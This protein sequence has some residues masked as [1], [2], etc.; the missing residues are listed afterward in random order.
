[1]VYSFFIALKGLEAP[2]IVLETAS[3][4]ANRQQAW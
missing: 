2:G 3:G 4:T 1:M